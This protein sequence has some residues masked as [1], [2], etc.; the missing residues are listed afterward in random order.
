MKKGKNTKGKIVSAAWDLFYDQGY[1]NTTID[2]IV[3]QSGTSNGS[4]YHYFESQDASLNSPSYLFDEKYEELAENISE[5]DNAFDTLIYLNQELFD[6]ID[7][8][9][10]HDLVA[11]LYSSQIVIKSERSLMDSSRVYYKL[12]RQIVSRGRE[13]GQIGTDMTV[14]EIVRYYAMCER[15]IIIEWCLAGYTFSLKNY[16]SETLPKMLETIK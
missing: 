15:A 2:E 3:E 9:V 14:N 10:D 1:E 5:D 12:I 4:F 13:K 8:K 16:A 6:M 7:N 11:R